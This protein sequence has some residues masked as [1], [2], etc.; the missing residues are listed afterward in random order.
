MKRAGALAVLAALMASG[1][2]V[3]VR[4]QE[5]PKKETTQPIAALAWRVGGVWTADTSRP[6]SGPGRIETRYQWSD[7]GAYIRFNT[8][9]ISE[10]GTLRNY[11]G[12]FFWNPEDASL[13]MWYTDAGGS[14]THGPVKLGGDI[15]EMTFHGE[16]FEGK[17]SDFRVKVTR[18]TN[19]DYSWLLEKKV[20]E[21]WKPLLALEY[22]RVAAS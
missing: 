1:T 4:S 21:G 22:L 2:W 11:D 6:G 19:D 18:K 9:F 14:I 13:E 5:T 20:P 8:H 3:A 10:K 17:P 12:S 16:D 7:N 15:M